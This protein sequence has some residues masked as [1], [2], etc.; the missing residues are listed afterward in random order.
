MRSEAC[1]STSKQMFLEAGQA[2][3]KHT[4]CFDKY[5]T[6]QNNACVSHLKS[7][8]PFITSSLSE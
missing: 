6:K 5:G 8:L 2:E 7:I 3:P 4:P 1:R